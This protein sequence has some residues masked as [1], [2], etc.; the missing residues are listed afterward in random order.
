MKIHLIMLVRTPAISDS[1][2]LSILTIS[3]LTPLISSDSLVLRV[4][5]IATPDTLRYRDRNDRVTNHN[6]NHPINR[7]NWD[8]SEYL[9]VKPFINFFLC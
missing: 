8:Y 9:L 5:R 7:S 6:P 4:T 1:N 2:P 3:A